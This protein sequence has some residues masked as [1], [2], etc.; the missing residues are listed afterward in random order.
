M[1]S[2]VGHEA[3]HLDHGAELPVGRPMQ[4]LKKGPLR[5]LSIL[6]L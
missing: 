5:P 4:K 3:A 2:T 1:R 6:V